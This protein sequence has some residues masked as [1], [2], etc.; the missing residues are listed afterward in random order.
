MAIDEVG[1]EVDGGSE[2][3]PRLDVLRLGREFRCP[4][5]GY[6]IVVQREPPPCPMCG[7]SAWRPLQRL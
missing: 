6:G 4:S 7:A 1:E 3:T 2:W 5:C